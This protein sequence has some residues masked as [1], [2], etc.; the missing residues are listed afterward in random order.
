MTLSTGAI[1]S[2]DRRRGKNK[3]RQRGRQGRWRTFRKWALRSAL[4]MGA[5]VLV[6]G[7]FLL[8]KGILK[9]NEVFKGGGDAVAL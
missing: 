7:G 8:F 2:S 4:V 1:S 6:I 3:E 5:L 9:I